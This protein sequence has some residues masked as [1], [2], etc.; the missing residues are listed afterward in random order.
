MC[1]VLSHHFFQKDRGKEALGWKACPGCSIYIAGLDCP[2][3]RVLV[4][5]RERPEVRA[6]PATTFVIDSPE[7]ETPRLA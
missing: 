3:H 4:G 2:E 1:V 7:T 5:A 6:E